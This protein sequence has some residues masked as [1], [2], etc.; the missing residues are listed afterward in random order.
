MYEGP[1][2]PAKEP[3]EGLT[4]WLLTGLPLLSLLDALRSAE[5]T[6]LVRSLAERLLQ[7]LI[8]AEASAHTGAGLH[9]RTE[10]RTARRNG[11]RPGRGLP[12][13]APVAHRVP[14]H[15]PDATVRR[16]A[17]HFRAEAEGLRRRSVAAGW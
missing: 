15:L 1:A 3:H 13:P 8:E 14:I 7:E 12:R 17:L 9:E 11:H 4:Q 16:E 6:D 10:T 5:S 2:E